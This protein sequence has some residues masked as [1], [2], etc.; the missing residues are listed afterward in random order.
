[1]I[2][3]PLEPASGQALRQEATLLV[4][5]VIYSMQWYVLAPAMLQILTEYRA[6]AWVSGILP[7]AF[8]AGA[9]STQLVSVALSARI[10]ARNTFI[11]GLLV[12]S[13][14]DMLMYFANGVW[15]AVGLRLLAGLGTGLFF[16]PAGFV[17]V[18]VSGA[19]SAALM[20]LFNSAFNIGGLMALAWGLVDGVLGWR[21]GTLL[22]GLLG[23][24]MVALSAA[25][26]KFNGRP[27]PVADG[28]ISWRGL[29]LIG[30]AGAGSFGASYAFGFFLPSIAKLYFGASPYSSGS[31]TLLMFAGAAVG[32][33][34]LAWL[35]RS[36][37]FSRRAV[38]LLLLISSLS[39]LLIYTRS[40]ELFLAASFINGLLVDVA[41]SAYYAY[42]V[43][44]YGRGRSATSLAVINMINMAASLWTFPLAGLALPDGL[45]LEAA[46]LAIANA[47]TIPFLYVAT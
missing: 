30:V 28:T 16:A 38:A 25:F 45:L 46:S 23:I 9:A 13:L 24:V 22:A 1:L 39:Y 5:R 37:S 11:L 20:G 15:E 42:T 31:L 36:W 4:T 40:Y 21:L 18:S 35:P 29:L 7:L 8:I 47:V 14:S 6:P 33:F 32:G 19:S 34:S 10:G 26:I 17:L 12:L 27:A 43:D 2:F 44:T 3:R 41:F